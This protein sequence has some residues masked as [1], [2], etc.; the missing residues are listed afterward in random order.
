MSV[1]RTTAMR[2]GLG[3]ASVTGLVAALLLSLSDRAPGLLYTAAL[4]LDVADEIRF[5]SLGVDPFLIGHFALWAA[6]A[7]VTSLALG[8]WPKM[9]PAA[10]VALFALGIVV[11][12]AQRRYTSTRG[13]ELQDVVAN[14]AG[15]VAG[16]MVVALISRRRSV[17][18]AYR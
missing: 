6:V 15:L 18:Q 1:E 3:L 11:E 4:R 7:I 17:E 2:V 5:A 10:L 8:Q 12:E 14:G 16:A 9:M 13:F